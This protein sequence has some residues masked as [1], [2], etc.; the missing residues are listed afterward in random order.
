MGNENSSTTLFGELAV[1]HTLTPQ[2]QKLL[3][4]MI[5]PDLTLCISS[6]GSSFVVSIIN[7]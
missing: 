6:P 1:P 5:M 4:T 3:Y 7:Q 2:G